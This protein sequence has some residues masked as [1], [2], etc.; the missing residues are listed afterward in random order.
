MNP[1]LSMR[2]GLVILL[3]VAA[4]SDAARA[5]GLFG[6]EGRATLGAEIRALLLA[7]PEILEPALNPPSAFA[8][9]VS[10]DLSR[11]D[12]LAPRLFDPALAGFGP[13]NAALQI[14]VFIHD[15][16]S[17]CAR[18]QDDL[19]ALVKDHDLRVTLHRMDDNGAGAELA[20]ALELS[21]A[22]SYV[23]PD[24]MIQGHMP[25]VVL[26]RYLTR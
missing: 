20:Q 3:A 26:E 23:L 4:G 5:D 18:A 21:E 9:A 7:E 10:A 1:L 25:P 6:P 11:L 2:H 15:A 8:E 22:P 12:D 13:Q 16:C 24:M 14:A 19:Q 17:D